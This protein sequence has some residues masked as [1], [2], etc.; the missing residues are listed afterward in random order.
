MKK[1]YIRTRIC[2][3]CNKEIIYT[4]Y[5][6]FYMAKKRNS[7]CFVCSR[8]GENN[9]FFGKNHSEKSKEKIG[10]YKRS[11]EVKSQARDLLKLVTNTRAIYDIWIEKFGKEK[12]DNLN[13][14]WKAKLSTAMS[15]ENNPMFNKPSPVGSGNGW[16]GWYNDFYFRSLRELSYVVQLDELKLDW[17]SAEIKELRI[18][19]L[20]YKNTKRTYR[21]DFLVE[22]K[23]L[24]EC[25]PIKLMKSKDVILKAEAAK[26]FC[27]KNNLEYLLVDPVLIDKEKLKTLIEQGNVKFLPKYEAKYNEYIKD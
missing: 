22:N 15:G 21:A 26:E 18:N 14:N 7:L 2:L 3:K 12:A 9:P 5:F 16:S 1:E 4:N 11:E 17:K 19:Y 25:K 10:K 6:S 8:S 13:L 20:D 24:I 27:L 23:Y